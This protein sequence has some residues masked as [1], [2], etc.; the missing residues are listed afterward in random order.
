MIEIPV[1]TNVPA[2]RWPRSGVPE[3]FFSV[4]SAGG[5][6]LGNGIR[7]FDWTLQVDSR[8]GLLSVESFRSDGDEAGQPLGVFRA[9]MGDEALG[10]FHK[11]VTDAKLGE[12]RPAMKGHPGY[13]ERL[14]TMAE[15]GRSEIR[16][17]INNS[18]VET[19]AG[20]APLRYKITALLAGIFEHPERAAQLDFGQSGEIFTVTVKNSG[21]EKICFT[22]PRWIETAG[23]MRRAVVMMTEFPAERAGAALVWKALPLAAM[24]PRPTVE[25]LITMAPGANW[26][27]MSPVGKRDPGKRYLA[28]FSWAN[29]AGEPM[30]SGSYRIRGR[31]DSP[32][33]VM[34]GG[35]R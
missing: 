14:Y 7:E 32:R 27:T 10:E 33:V 23:V 22:D 17:V 8:R 28:Y 13:T 31:A 5:Q 9:A 12:L 1:S 30:V 25:P 4:R 3:Y 2:A 15:A 19:N 11:L 29:Y 34:E 16:R 24:Q 26:K 6:T 35:P 20:I 18:D 21:V